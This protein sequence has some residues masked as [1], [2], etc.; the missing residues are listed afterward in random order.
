MNLQEHQQ[1]AEIASPV[2]KTVTMWATIAAGIGVNTWA[3]AASFASFCAAAI[4]ALYSLALLS[5]WFWKKVWRPLA[6]EVGLLK[7]RKTNDDEN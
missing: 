1:A 3:E 5:E 4:G 7:P 2:A 6:V